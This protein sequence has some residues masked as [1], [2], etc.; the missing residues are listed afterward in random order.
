MK[1]TLFTFAALVMLHTS[2]GQ[3]NLTTSINQVKAGINAGSDLFWNTSSNAQFEVPAGNGSHAIF[4]GNL[5]IGGLDSSDQ[6]HLAAQTYRQRGID[7]FQGPIMSSGNYSA[8]TDAL[9]NVVWK[10]NKTT[11]DSFILWTI[12]PNQYPNYVVPAIIQN[13]PGNG[14]VNLGQTPRLLP[15]VDVD[16][17]GVYNYNVGDYPC[18]KGD[19][20]IFIIFNDDRNAHTETGGTKLGIQVI[21]MLYGYH[22]SG[23]PV[24]TALFLEYQISNLSS[25]NYHDVYVGNWTDFDLGYAFDD[26]IGCD[27][28]RQLYYAYNGGANDAYYGSNP[29]AQCVMY[30]NMPL[31]PLNDAVDNDQDGS[32]DELGEQ[33]T[34][35]YFKMYSNDFSVIGDPSNA[36][37]FYNYISGRWRDSSSVTYGSN[38]YQGLIPAKYM[39]PAASDP[40]GFGTGGVPQAP[41]DEISAGFGD[42]DRRGV[43]S[44]GPF[45]LNAG[46]TVSCTY[47]YV[48]GRGSAGPASSIVAMQNAADAVR[49]FYNTTQASACNPA[50]TGL[51]YLPKPAEMSVF[52]NPANDL[53]FVNFTAKNT[54]AQFDIMD[55]TG[56]VLKS[57]TLATASQQVISLNGLPAGVYLLRINDGQTQGTIRFVKQ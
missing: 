38:G 4:A 51:G 8:A 2:W 52:P 25:N 43:G 19:Q 21:A 42:G 40:N 48:Y 32:I 49:A 57:E 10:I 22:L 55:V 36:E 7:F 44:A 30:L 11:I 9:W 35:N 1:N 26:R 28:T 39:F 15:Y 20:A 24:D 16:G 6:L 47:A 56:R 33:V 29:P 53:L 27:V 50:P 13:W 45:L 5:W 17:D 54:M 12:N 23:S 18:I 46:T 34:M 14:N 3:S 31:A 41:W 37:G